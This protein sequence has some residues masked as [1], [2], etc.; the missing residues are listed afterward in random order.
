MNMLETCLTIGFGAGLTVGFTI[1]RWIFQP[2]PWGV[3]KDIQQMAEEEDRR[4]GK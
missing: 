3:P 2:A 1:G 4:S